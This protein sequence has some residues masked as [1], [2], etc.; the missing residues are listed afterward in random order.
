MGLKYQLNDLTGLDESVKALYE[1]KDGKYVL[2]IEGLPSGDDVAGLKAKVEEL[3]GE[4]KAGQAKAAAEAERARQAEEDAAKKKGDFESLSN[5]YAE[6]IAA[7]EKRIA[8]AQ[9]ESARKEVQRQATLIAAELAE[10][11]NQELL[12]TFIERRLKYEEGALKVVD[13]NGNLTIS[14]VDQLKEEFRSN[15]K[16]GALVVA[17]KASGGGASGAKNA[18]G[19]AAKTMSR[20]QFEGLDPAARMEFSKSGGTLTES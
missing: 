13:N 7:Y 19:G 9:T 5:S 2:K 6:K 1:Q 11:P 4:K 16:F 17:T 20:G 14:T 12:S 15:T 3:L 8:D 18:G 10:G